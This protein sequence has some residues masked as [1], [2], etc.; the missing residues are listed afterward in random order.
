MKYL[1]VLATS[2]SL[3]VSVACTKQK[4]ASEIADQTSAKESHDDS[5]GYHTCPMHPQVHN[6]EPGPCPICGMALVKVQAP[7][8]GTK[9]AKISQVDATDIQL[10]LA[11]IAKHKVARKDLVFRIPASGRFVSA[12]EI[13]FQIY[14]SDLSLIRSGIAFTGTPATAPG[15]KLRGTLRL[16]DSFIDPGS[17]TARVV[18]SL[19]RPFTRASIEGG[20]LGEFEIE[21]KNQ[22]AIPE[23]AVLHTGSRDLTYVFDSENKLRAVKVTLGKKA[24]A[25]YQVLSGLKEG[26]TIS[27]GSNFLIDSETKIRGVE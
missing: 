1:P 24:G 19:S 5:E 9:A 16:V 22:I 10:A 20:F 18:G 12:Q 11:G 26:E 14:E 21:L 17:R 6:H 23:D 2:L 13:A 15:E 7:T 25:E 4:T 3:F 27:R 8:Q